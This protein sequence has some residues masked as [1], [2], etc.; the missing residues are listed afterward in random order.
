V[1]HPCD[2]CLKLTSQEQKFCAQIPILTFWNVSL[3][4]SFINTR[5]YFN[6]CIYKSASGPHFSKWR[7]FTPYPLPIQQTLIYCLLSV[8]IGAK[9]WNFNTNNI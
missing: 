6:S 5:D 7:T 1:L 8:R 4:V 3:A 2:H 9:Y